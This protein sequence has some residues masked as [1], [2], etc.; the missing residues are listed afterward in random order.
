MN[1]S[2]QSQAQ[3]AAPPEWDQILIACQK[4]LPSRVRELIEQD[5]V[6][7]NHKN[8]IGQS[9]LH[10]AALWGHTECCSILLDHGADPLAQNTITGATPLHACVQ[11]SK[12]ATRE[13]KLN[14]IDLLLKKGANP[15][16]GDFYGSIPFD[17]CEEDDLEL[18]EKLKPSKPPIFEAILAD[19]PSSLEQVKALVS[20][21]PSLVQDRY[22]SMTPL[23]K[24]VQDM[25]EDEGTDH[26]MQTARIEIIKVILEAGADANEVPTIERHGHFSSSD[27]PEADCLQRVCTKLVE[28]YR[29]NHGKGI[30]IFS[31]AALLLRQHGATVGEQTAQLVHDAA[32]RGLIDVVGFWITKL[33]VDPNVRGR[34]G[35]TPLQF[36]ARSGKLEVVQFLLSVDTIDISIADD[37][38]Q[39]PLDAAKA[40]QK[41][42]I[43][44][45]IEEHIFKNSALKGEES[46][47]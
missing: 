18:R 20:E 24:V 47:P 37:R 16:M 11:S 44:K 38:G 32:R 15:S 41:A 45:A 1:N 19:N 12:A 43:V 30:E 46:E 8:A 34:Q 3:N 36:A 42:D 22:L 40:N 14:C 13:A 27:E 2:I 39:T 10:V 29:Q 6:S 25:C 26:D 21:T 33:N 31:R 17:Y 23:L 9:A 7:S 4:N 5:G 28:A 35:M